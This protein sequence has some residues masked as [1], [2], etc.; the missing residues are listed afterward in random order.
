MEFSFANKFNADDWFITSD[1]PPD[2]YQKYINGDKTLINEIKNQEQ[3]IYFV[4][5]F[6]MDYHYNK[7]FDK[8]TIL[9]LLSNEI[10]ADISEIKEFVY[11]MFEQ[12]KTNGKES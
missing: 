10:N 4:G 12:I 11:G 2:Q 1:L 6:I 9:K 3:L 8:E 7:G 5:N